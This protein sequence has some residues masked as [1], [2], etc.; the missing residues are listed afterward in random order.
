MVRL[1][2]LGL[3]LVAVA[4]VANNLSPNLLKEVS[5]FFQRETSRFAP[6]EVARKQ[7]PETAEQKIE[8]HLN[9]FD[10]AS[11]RIAEKHLERIRTFFRERKGGAKPFAD[12]AFSWGGKWQYAKGFL[13]GDN[14]AGFRQFLLEHFE[15]H[16]L[17][18]ADLKTMLES[19]LAAY[20]TDMQ[21]LENDMLVRLRADLAED[22]LFRGDVPALKSDEAFK[23][24]YRRM[25]EQVLPI[26]TE[27][28][29]VTIGREVGVFVGSEIAAQILGQG[30][31]TRLAVSGG[32]LGA[33]ANS[34]WV[35]FG[36]GLVAGVVIDYLL[37]WL[38][39]WVGYD[40][41]GGVATQV[42]QALDRMERQLIE[43][44]PA[45]VGNFVRLRQQERDEPEE[46]RRTQFRQQAE[47]IARSGAL[48]MRLQW[49][50]LQEMQSRLHL[51]AI[52]KLIAVSH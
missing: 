24:A 36:V 8:R 49:Q 6:S 17:T 52:R 41:A 37:D 35:T 5:E 48:G 10:Q 12:A 1:F 51:Q 46:E 25:E 14:G 16:V 3:A 15:K 7:K 43:G 29:K 28:L 4:M 22:E 2:A 31:A 34:G 19:T 45:A 18:D 20:V 23:E 27:D 50:G 42:E 44:D 21:G 47:G 39:R 9:N 40:P 11:V 30:L 32:I 26:V 13:A 33:A 38:L